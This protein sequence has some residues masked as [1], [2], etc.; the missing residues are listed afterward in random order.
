MPI[1]EL[2]KLKL[3]ELSLVDRPANPM[4]MAPIFKRDTSNGED[5]TDDVIK[6]SD[7]MDKK[8][9]DYMDKKGVDRKTAEEAM[10]KSL[11]EVQR[12]TK[13]LI[14]E[15]YRIEADSVEK[16]APV[17]Q[18]EFEGEMV[19][20]ADIPAPVLKRLEAMEKAEKE[21]EVAK[22]AEETLPNFDQEV[23]KKLVALDLD[24]DTLKALKAADAVFEK[25]MEEVGKSE[26]KGDLSD[27]ES[28]LDKMVDEYAAAH[29]LNKWDAYAEVAKT[30]EGKALI[31]K[32][33]KKED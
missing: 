6:M 29:K 12:L 1:N 26:D 10:M 9:K 8:I 11:D 33:Y 13:A 27:T 18:I 4:A 16:K 2:K 32:S 7:E 3:E 15:G 5:M 28:K 20:K 19:N 31:N 14:D 23:A 22:K 30:K 25:S 17:E 21:A 24:E